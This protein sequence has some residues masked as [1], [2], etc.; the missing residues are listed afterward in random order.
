MILD[1]Y[2]Y[3]EY[4]IIYIFDLYIFDF[5]LTSFIKKV[6]AKLIYHSVNFQIRNNKISP[7]CKPK[8]SEVT[9]QEQLEWCKIASRHRNVKEKSEISIWHTDI[10]LQR[11]KEKIY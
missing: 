3:Y 1:I 7:K 11:K 6:I 5:I 2:I 10:K 9:I 8:R 4:L